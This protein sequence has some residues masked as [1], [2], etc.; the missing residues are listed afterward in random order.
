MQKKIHL[1]NSGIDYVLFLSENLPA[2]KVVMVHVV[3]RLDKHT[4]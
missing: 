4:A 1:C 2:A 3:D